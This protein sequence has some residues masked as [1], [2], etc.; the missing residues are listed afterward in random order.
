MSQSVEGAGIISRWRHC[1]SGIVLQKG[2]T[3]IEALDVRRR[4]KAGREASK[5]LWSERDSAMKSGRFSGLER[6]LL[7]PPGALVRAI[8]PPLITK[9]RYE[10]PMQVREHKPKQHG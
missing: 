8:L 5:R 3:A 2:Q 6:A 9:E 1:G 10:R 7:P 4:W